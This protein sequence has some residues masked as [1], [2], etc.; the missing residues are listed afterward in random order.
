MFCSWFITDPSVFASHANINQGIENT[1][2]N[3][4]CKATPGYPYPK[5][6]I[7][8]YYSPQTATKVSIKVRLPFSSLIILCIFMRVFLKNLSDAYYGRSTEISYKILAQKL[9]NTKFIVCNLAQDGYSPR[10]ET[11]PIKVFCKCD[12]V[13]VEVRIQIT[14]NLFESISNPCLDS[15]G[16]PVFSH[17]DD[18]LYL[19]DNQKF[20]INC[21]TAKFGYYAPKLSISLNNEAHFMS[22][23]GMKDDI[24]G[25]L[26][27]ISLELVASKKWHNK[28][29]VC[30]VEQPSFAPQSKSITLQIERKVTS[31]H[32]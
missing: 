16:A 32:C 27:N 7:Q 20:Q 10:I 12:E 13:L 24:G 31:S 28:K 2:I 19:K 29:V 17:T 30:T 3:I 23:I 26:F 4:T 9:M 15:A 5:T 21:T 18:V 8:G 6:H 22:N 11:F 25:E 14:C 1:I